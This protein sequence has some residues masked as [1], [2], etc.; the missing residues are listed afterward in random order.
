MSSS[1]QKEKRQRRREYAQNKISL[2]IKLSTTVVLNEPHRASF[3]LIFILN[4]KNIRKNYG[5]F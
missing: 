1:Q 4:R 5:V 3:N 2:T